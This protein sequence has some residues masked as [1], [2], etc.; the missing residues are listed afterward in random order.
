MGGVGCDW[1]QR[2]GEV[3]A[4][5]CENTG[6]NDFST[7]TNPIIGIVILCGQEI[8]SERE[9]F[10][11]KIFLHFLLGSLSSKTFPIPQG[12]S[13]GYLR[14]SENTRLQPKI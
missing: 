12:L 1:L 2:Y 9:G 6:P 10:I 4:N 8:P 11:V 7:L 14:S 13:A 5:H 3:V